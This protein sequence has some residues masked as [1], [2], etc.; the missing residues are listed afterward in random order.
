MRPA[1]PDTTAASCGP[2]P[3]NASCSRASLRIPEPGS[4]DHLG[5]LDPRVAV[6]VEGE[7]EPFHRTDALMMAAVCTQPQSTQKT[8]RAAVPLRVLRQLRFQFL[9]C[10]TPLLR[11]GPSAR[12][13]DVR[14]H[15]L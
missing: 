4:G 3:S 10:C 5:Q 14:P 9:A 6:F 15:H 13:G 1:V 11:S 2:P 7:G 12:S 8:Q